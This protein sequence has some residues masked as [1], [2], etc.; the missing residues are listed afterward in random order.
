MLGR[1]KGIGTF[2]ASALVIGSVLF[3]PSASALI[4]DQDVVRPAA[5]SR[6][7]EQIQLQLAEK[8]RNLADQY[9]N[10][11]F[12]TEENPVVEEPASI[13]EPVSAEEESDLAGLRNTQRSRLTSTEPSS[14]D[15]LSAM[16][17][18]GGVRSEPIAEHL[19]KLPSSGFG[20]SAAAIA[21]GITGAL[22]G[23]KKFE[24]ALS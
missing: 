11:R 15:V 23:R 8:T 20:L 6:E 19:P 16:A 1:R 18:T 3:A 5:P 9:T 7:Q 14:S 24:R 13:P 22:R 2:S 17:Q 12:G 4:I 10:R 21:L